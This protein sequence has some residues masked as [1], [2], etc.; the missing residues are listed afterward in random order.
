M[1]DIYCMSQKEIDLD[2]IC[3]DLLLNCEGLRLKGLI[4]DNHFELP[5]QNI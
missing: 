1:E 4:N 2:S 3:I 5:N